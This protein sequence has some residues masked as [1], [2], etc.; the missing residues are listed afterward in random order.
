[1]IHIKKNYKMIYNNTLILIKNVQKLSHMTDLFKGSIH[2]ELHKV[3]Q[4]KLCI[5]NQQRSRF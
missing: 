4:K 3:Y 2:S 1:M 5:L